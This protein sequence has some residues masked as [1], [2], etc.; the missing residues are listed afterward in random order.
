[1]NEP[2]HIFLA[3]LTAICA[4]GNGYMVYQVFQGQ[5]Q[6]PILMSRKDLDK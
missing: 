1:M 6:K 3:V 2:A 5:A 4:L